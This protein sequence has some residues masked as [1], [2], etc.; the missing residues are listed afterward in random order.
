MIAAAPMRRGVA[1]GT[2]AQGGVRLRQRRRGLAVRA[3]HAGWSAPGD[4]S[5]PYG[6]M[7]PDRLNAEAD[8]RAAP[9]KL[10]LDSPGI[11]AA[12]DSFGLT[13]AVVRLP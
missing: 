6:H 4:S 8:A 13:T 5:P 9:A 10:D 11:V 1:G 7:S 12:V 3:T 2:N